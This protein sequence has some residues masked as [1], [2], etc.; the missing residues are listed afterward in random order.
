MLSVKSISHWKIRSSDGPYSYSTATTPT[1]PF[2]IRV[3]F[4]SRLGF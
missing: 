4:G 2:S 1:D 3:G